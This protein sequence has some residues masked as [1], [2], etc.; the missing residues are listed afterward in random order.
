VDVGVE[1]ETVDVVLVDVPDELDDE[2]VVVGLV[3]LDELDLDDDDAV[4]GLHKLF[5]AMLRPR[6]RALLTGTANSNRCCRCRRRRTR[7]WSDHCSP[8]HRLQTKEAMSVHSKRSQERSRTLSVHLGLGH[9]RREQGNESEESAGL[10][11]GEGGKVEV[12]LEDFLPKHC[13]KPAAFIGHWVFA[14]KLRGCSGIATQRNGDKSGVHVLD[15]RGSCGKI[16]GERLGAGGNAPFH[17]T[18]S[19]EVVGPVS[20]SRR[21]CSVS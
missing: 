5:N 8:C 15:K 9:S 12:E 17:G 16:S 7:R 14:P 20:T 21:K 3:E 11:H 4:P 2:I 19:A 10:E 6:G 13:S 1:D 18:S